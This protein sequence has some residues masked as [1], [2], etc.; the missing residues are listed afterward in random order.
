[1]PITQ[2]AKKAIRGSLR[3]QASNNSRKRAMKEIIKKI[4]KVSKTDK[5]EAFKM[6]SSA[7]AIIDKAAKKNVI[8]KN[9]A[10]RKKSRLSRLTR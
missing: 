5:K 8:K 9:N 10:A 6:L 4:E 7:F 1:M 3:R 2:S